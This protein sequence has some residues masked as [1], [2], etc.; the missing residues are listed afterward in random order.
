VSCRALPVNK[1]RDATWAVIL[2]AVGQWFNEFPYATS[3][4]ET[5]DDL[6]SAAHN[7][8]GGPKAPRRFSVMTLAPV[9]EKPRLYT[10]EEAL[11][12]MRKTALKLNSE[13]SPALD[14]V[15]LL[16]EYDKEDL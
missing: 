6:I 13:V 12:L 10:Q 16:E 4:R 3:Y 14:L 9:P 1:R 11:L 8:D 7:I 15:K 2:R 5:A